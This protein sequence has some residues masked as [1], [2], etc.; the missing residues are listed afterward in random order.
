MV[1]FVNALELLIY[2]TVIKECTV[3]YTALA[4]N[5]QAYSLPSGVTWNDVLSVAIGDIEYNKLNATINSQ[6]GYWYQDSK[7]FLYPVP[8]TA[9]DSYVSGASKITFAT[10]TITT[11]DDDFEEFQVGD[12][13]LISGCTVNTGNNKYALVITVADKV[14]TVP[15]STFTAG[16]ET[17]AITIAVPSMKVVSRYHP[18]KKA[19]AN[20]ATDTLLLPDSFAMLYNYYIYAEISDLRRE[21]GDSQQW[22]LKFNS[23]LTDFIQWYQVNQAHP[24]PAHVTK[25]WK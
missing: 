11:T 2:D 19:V 8:D 9:D 16:L 23:K 18:T 7:I 10:N 22:R 21:W 5:I 1:S 3:N 6:K 25:R 14:L 4:A 20:I 12:Y 13:I 24:A 17:A 15:A